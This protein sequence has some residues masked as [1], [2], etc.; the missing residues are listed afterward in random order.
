[1]KPRARQLRKDQT[2]A[3]TRLWQYLRNRQLTD[4]KFRRQHVIGPYIVDFVCL[5]KKLIVELDGGHHL[6][7]QEYD[8]LRTLE[9]NSSG[10]RVL[11]FW[12]NEVLAEPDR[13]LEVILSALHD[14]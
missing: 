7:Q 2:L 3:E 5:E 10:F 14:S 12:N 13:I 8:Q 9:L 11:R 1:M 6:E 4:C